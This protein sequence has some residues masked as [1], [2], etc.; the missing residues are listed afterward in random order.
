MEANHDIEMLINGKYPKWLRERILSDKG[1]LS[2]NASGFYLSKLIGP[3]TKKV[4][5]AHL[6][7][8]NNTSEKA[9]K[10]V[11]DTLKEYEIDFKNI[12]IAKQREK[13]KEY[14]I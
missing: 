5:L 12:D 1:H 9:K 10:T 8:E 14:K 11:L 13:T 2:N 6:S 7:K 3:D 4:I